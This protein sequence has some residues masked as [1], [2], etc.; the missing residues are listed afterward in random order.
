MYT[1]KK[2]TFNGETRDIGSLRI[3]VS[4]NEGFHWVVPTFSMMC[5]VVEQIIKD[6]AK[7]F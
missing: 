7:D 4:W 2:A 6:K 1:A 3:C 5:S